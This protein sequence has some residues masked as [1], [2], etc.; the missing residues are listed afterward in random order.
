MTDSLSKKE[1]ILEA[2]KALG[3]V[4]SEEL[5][6]E[7]EIIEFYTKLRCFSYAKKQMEMYKKDKHQNLQ[8]SKSFSTKLNAAEQ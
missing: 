2:C 4:D 6:V 8:K 5:E 1:T 3:L 7:I